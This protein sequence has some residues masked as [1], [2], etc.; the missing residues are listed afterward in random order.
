MN[1]Q[2]SAIVALPADLSE[3]P[4]WKRPTFTILDVESGTVA[5]SGSVSDGSGSTS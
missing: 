1:N 5:T 4:A 2:E 3:A